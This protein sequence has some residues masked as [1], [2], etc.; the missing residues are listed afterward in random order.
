MSSLFPLSPRPSWYP[1]WQ[2]VKDEGVSKT[3]M[4]KEKQVGLRRN[5][6]KAFTTNPAVVLEAD[7]WLKTVQEIRGTDKVCKRGL[8][9]FE[10]HE[11]ADQWMEV[12][13]LRSSQESRL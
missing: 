7:R 9:K 10:T 8:Y 2:G 3:G 13:I 5:L 11:E 12:M 4:G 6:D 1:A